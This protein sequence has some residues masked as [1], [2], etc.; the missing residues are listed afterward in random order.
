M[1]LAPERPGGSSRPPEELTPGEPATGPLSVSTCERCPRLAEGIE[2]IGEYEDSGFKEAPSLVRRGDGQVIQLPDLLYQVVRKVD[3]DR[4]YEEIAGELSDE[5]KRGLD[6]DSVRFLVEEKLHP[7]GIA[8]APDGT[9]P[10]VEKPD[11]FLG[12]KFRAAVVPE[13][14]SGGLGTAFMPLFFPL[15]VLAIMG[16][17]VVADWWLFGVH[18]WPSRCARPSTTPPS[19]CLCSPPSCCP[20]ASTR[21]GTPL[22]AGTAAASPGRWAAGCT[23]PGLPSTR[24]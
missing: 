2:L 3:G 22:P 21:S 19:S 12:L 10:K 6:A 1:T 11:P 24:T 23:W 20:P 14:V 15:I 7:L 17:F 9:S 8:C 18:G 4:S 5:I 16:A 13:A